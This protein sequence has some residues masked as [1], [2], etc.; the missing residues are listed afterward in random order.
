LSFHIALPLLDPFLAYGVHPEGLRI[1][2]DKIPKCFMLGRLD[3]ADNNK[4]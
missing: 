1:V 2:V 3:V 4:M